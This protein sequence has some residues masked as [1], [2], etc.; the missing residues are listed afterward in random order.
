MLPKCIRPML[1]APAREPFDSDDWLF[2]VKWDGIRCLAFVE[3]GRVR[4]QSRRLLDLT[5]QFPELGC[6]LVLPD[7]TVLDGEL[8]VFELGR[9][10]LRRV[11]ERMPSQKR[12]RIGL[13]DARA[14][15]VVFDLLYRRGE[16]IM[17]RP[18]AER[19]ALL[20]ELLAH[21]WG[22]HAVV[23][24]AV[25]GSGRDYFEGIRKLNLEG[26]MAKRLTSP[27]LA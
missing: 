26:M 5:T 25:T 10:S 19:R 21:N 13:S 16:S 17:N 1:A 3:G 2:E 15:L 23:P 8:V 6:L 14:T 22:P 20:S 27:Y 18:L 4:L 12:K 9:P 7:G 11:L 24:D